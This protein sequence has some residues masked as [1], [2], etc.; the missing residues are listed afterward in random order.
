[1]LVLSRRLGEEIV[2]DGTI[3]V[4]IVSIQGNRVKLGVVAPEQVTVHR[5]EI[6]R[7]RMEFADDLTHV[8]DAVLVN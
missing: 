5:E 2:I 1:M 6:H 3:R 4:K 8:H 7:N